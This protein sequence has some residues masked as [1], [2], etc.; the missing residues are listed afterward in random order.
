IC[1]YLKIKNTRRSKT[2]ASVNDELR[3][4]A[5]SKIAM[6]MKGRS[7]CKFRL[8]HVSAFGINDRNIVLMRRVR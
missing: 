5:A 4:A 7:L 3:D 2:A 6:L 8:F 1:S